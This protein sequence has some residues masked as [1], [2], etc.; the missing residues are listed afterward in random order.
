MFHRTTVLD[1]AQDA[2]TKIDSLGQRKYGGGWNVGLG[3]GG[4]KRKKNKTPLRSV[5]DSSDNLA[6]SRFAEDDTDDKILNPDMRAAA[7]AAVARAG[8]A[9]SD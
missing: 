5:A 8:G 1:V 3:R 2:Q 4:F 6:S 9:S 7:A